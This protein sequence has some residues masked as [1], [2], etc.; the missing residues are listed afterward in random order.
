MNQPIA[1]CSATSSGRLT[2]SAMTAFMGNQVQGGGLAP[3]AQTWPGT[4]P[5]SPP[6]QGWFGRRR[7][8]QRV[9]DGATELMAAGTRDGHQAL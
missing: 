5:R 2:P 7:A 3:T 6:N 4:L 1:R 8:G 9:P